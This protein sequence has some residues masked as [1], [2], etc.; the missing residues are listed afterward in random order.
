MLFNFTKNHKF[1]TRLT[2]NN[3]NIELVKEMKLLGVIVTND[4]KWHKNTKH[5][6]KK[7]WA[8][9]QLLKKVAEFGA[10]TSDKL[11]IYK[12]FVRSALEQSCTVWH[13]SLTKGN[14]REIERVQK[15]AVRLITNQTNKTYK[16]QL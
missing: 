7:S 1:T 8:R 2:L 15:A 12:T 10:S 14:E 5:V 4:L 11:T 6:V 3:K 9:I 16:E 13:S